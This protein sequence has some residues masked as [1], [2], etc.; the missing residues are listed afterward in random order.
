MLGDEVAHLRIDLLAP[1]AAAEDAVVAG[2]L[3][4]EVLAVAF[5]DAGAQLV[6][7]AGLA[8]AGDVVELAFDGQQ[9]G[10]LDR[11]PDRRARR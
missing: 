8:Q 1:A 6:R 7:G 2:A 5:G 11:S 9:R 3:D 10:V 4:G